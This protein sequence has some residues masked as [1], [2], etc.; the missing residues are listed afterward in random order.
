MS[1][2]K[3]PVPK[4]RIKNG[5][6]FI[7]LVII[8]VDLLAAQGLIW[9]ANT[10]S[11]FDAP[12]WLA[13]LLVG[14]AVVALLVGLS[15]RM[16]KD[17]ESAGVE[18]SVRWLAGL[19]PYSRW[20]ALIGTIIAITFV[21]RRIPRL[22]DDSSYTV[23]FLVWLLA[24][25]FYFG[26]VIPRSEW[27][28]P[29]SDWWRKRDSWFWGVVALVL[30]ALLLRVWRIGDIPFTLGG[31]EGSQGLEALRVI[32]GSLRN[33]FTTGWLG[34]P[35]ISFFFNSL[36][37]RLLGPTIAG[38]RLPWALVGTATVWVT[39]LLVKQ[40]A[41]RRMG[42]VT[43]VLLATYHYH[44]HYSRLGSNQVADPF[45]LA[46]ALLFLMRARDG[47][48]RL[49]W[50]LLGAVSGLAFYFYAGARL[51]PVVVTAVLGYWFI[52]NPRRFWREH[53]G[54]VLVAVWAFLVVASP[55]IQY[56]VRFPSDFNARLNQVGIIQSGWLERE[57]EVRGQSQGAILFDQF[58][59]AALAF[60][61]YPDRTVWYGLKEPL[62][63]PFFGGL[64]LLGLLY[65]TLRLLTPIVGRRVAPLAAWWWGGM[66]LGGMLTESPPS[67]QRLI[68]LAVPTC[69]FLAYALNEL[70]KLTRQAI[71][72]IPEKAALTVLLTAFAFTSL[73]TYFVDYTPLRLY[74]GQNAEMAT[75]IAPLL[76]EL[77]Y[78]H[79]F[80]FVGAPWM[81]WGFATLPYLV[82]DAVASDIIDPLTEPV[83]P[84]LR[85]ADKGVV[86]IVLP[87][88]QAE[89]DFLLEPA[90]PD[91]LRR[92]VY[93][94]VDGRLMVTLYRLPR[95][96]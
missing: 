16:Y 61:Y 36:S 39:Y 1:E 84:D 19:R 33:P 73:K 24:V 43:A 53:G 91:G 81:Y 95:Q 47:Q 59:R 90:F 82:P 13:V 42:M 85:P 78:N 94:P 20:L 3:D 44:I 86:F 40:V 52:L 74:G 57:V 26:A 37:L 65:G 45:F 28:R 64:F 29:W 38:L 60:N 6:L 76:N 80:Q 49:D 63:D 22:T 71:G 11:P 72:H 4:F 56:A 41:G 34:V 51:T 87:E 10:Q 30:G 79:E 58:Q 83:S 14:V 46:L 50:A 9:H 7:W 62:L 12:P 88:R 8:L 54:G 27:R 32:S 55:M 18:L 70:L 92:E 96:R 31:D 17:D 48:R 25:V 68:T 15:S 93:S 67:S 23:V 75:Q 35:T 66:V 69:F 89:L 77:K 5:R 21:L 2:N